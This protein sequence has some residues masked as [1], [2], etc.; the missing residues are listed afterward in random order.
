MTNVFKSGKM[1]S[2]YID[3]LL[4]NGKSSSSIIDGAIVVLKNLE[5]NENVCEDYEYDTYE[6][7][8]PLVS[9]ED[10]ALVDYGGI[11]EGSIEKNQ[12]KLGNKLVGL[13]VP[14]NVLTRVRIP[15]LHDKFWLGEG[16]F[17]SKPTVGQ[18]ATVE[19]G[20]YL[21]KPTNLLPNKGYAVKIIAKEVLTVGMSS[22]G[23]IY[24]CEVV[25]LT[26]KKIK[27]LLNASP[28]EQ[29]SYLLDE[30]IGTGSVSNY[31]STNSDEILNAVGFTK[32]DNVS[33]MSRIL[34]DRLQEGEIIT[35]SMND[36][37][38]IYLSGQ[39]SEETGRWKFCIEYKLPTKAT[40][41]AFPAKS[42]YSAKKGKIS[43]VLNPAEVVK[44][45]EYGGCIIAYG[46]TVNV[47]DVV[48][49][50]GAK[51]YTINIKDLTYPVDEFNSALIIDPDTTKWTVSSHEFKLPDENALGIITIDGKPAIRKD[52]KSIL[53]K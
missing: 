20:S 40:S 15:Y 50:N 9:T 11:S 46:Y 17:S 38:T 16:N 53:K 44:T 35:A 12:Y 10:I 19:V 52:I 5:E 49:W 34:Y 1:A 18:Y 45:K 47:D 41:A 39:F 22:S 36:G 29:V 4:T 51:E 32:E 24:L 33:N 3:S 31:I 42:G 14:Q 21:H 48:I 8:V 28:S 7:A 6:L 26:G 25:Q 13:T 43:I 27:D 30:F 37:A 23:T 2:N